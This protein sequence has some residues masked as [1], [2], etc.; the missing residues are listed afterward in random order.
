LVSG[1]V[2]YEKKIFKSS[3]KFIHIAFQSSNKLAETKSKNEN[4]IETKENSLRSERLKKIPQR[5]DL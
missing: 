1:F 4:E 2:I 3:C 5:L